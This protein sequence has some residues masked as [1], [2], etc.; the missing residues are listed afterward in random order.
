MYQDQKVA[1]IIPAYNEAPSIGPVVRE[2]MAMN[3]NGQRLVDKVIVCDNA[4]TDDTAKLAA[5]HGAHVIFEPVLGYGRACQSALTQIEDADVVVFIDGDH[6]AC[7]NEIPLLLQA[8][9][10]GA[11]LVIGSRTK[12][13]C[14]KGAL[15]PHQIFGNRLA[16]TLTSLWWHQ[17]VTDL[18]PFRAID[19]EVLQTL[20]MQDLAYGW[21]MEMQA[22]ALALNMQ[23]VEVPVSTRKRIGTSKVSGTLR[24]TLG[25]TLGILGMLV[26]VAWKYRTRRKSKL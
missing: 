7:A 23:L 13:I 19:A 4:S 16:T 6:S 25:A 8:W 12:G 3:Y 2:V 21:T 24:G 1:V 18:G 10:S 22:K 26:K 20:N 9:A 11:D 15:L 17:S 14:A 5:H